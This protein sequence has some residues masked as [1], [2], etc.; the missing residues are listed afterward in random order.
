MARNRGYAMKLSTPIYNLK[1]QAKILS[2]QRQIPL[3]AALD[4]V[5]QAE[6]FQNWSLLASRASLSS[7]AIE[8]LDHIKPG[9]LVLLGARPGH[10]KSLMGLDLV[11]KSVQK[12][13]HGWFF[14]LEWNKKDVEE[15]LRFLGEEIISST[16]L[17]HFDGSDSISAKYIIDQLTNAA[18][19]TL[20]VIDY[21]QILD[22]RR[23]TP[24]ISEQVSNLKTFARQQKVIIVCISQIDRSF[25]S[26]SNPTPTIS[27]VKLPNPLDLQLFDRSCF[28]HNGR[29]EYA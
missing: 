13:N 29:V 26:T 25:E 17:F 24:D 4:K 21:L 15:Q 7:P 12:G 27:D 11:V 3:H 10:G 22:Q 16:R 20:A 2:R 8:M 28:L 6:G 9:E 19:G 5:A 18:T 23:S 14:T 1:R